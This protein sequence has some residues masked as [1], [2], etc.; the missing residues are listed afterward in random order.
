MADTQVALASRIQKWDSD[1][2]PEYVRESGFMPYMGKASGKGSNPGAII[3]T[4][5]DLQAS[6]KV[7]NMP[8]IGRTRGPGVRGNKRLTGAEVALDNY[9]CPITVKTIRQAHRVSEQEEHW[10]E[11]D[12]RDAMKTG[13]RNWSAEYLRDDFIMAFADVWGKSWAGGQD[14]ALEDDEATIYTPT[15]FMAALNADQTNMDAW[16]SANRDRVLYGPDL[17]HME[18]DYDHSDSVV[19]LTASTDKASA[20]VLRLA[21]GRAKTAGSE[22]GWFHIKPTRAEMSEG[23]EYFVWFVGSADFNNLKLDTEIAQANRDAR[24]RGVDNHPIF[25]DG[26]LIFDGVIIREIP[27]IPNFGNVGA[28]SAPVTMSFFCGAQAVGLAWAKRPSSRVSTDTDYGHFTGLAI[29]EMRAA[30][31][32]IFNTRQTGVVTVFCTAA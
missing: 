25:Q 6:G 3:L 5:T 31:K 14:A 24:A 10:T 2:Q 11:M 16:L 13:L 8:F 7:I 21:K 1:Y 12:L 4:K 30:K 29:S 32:L 18:A 28:T 26:D 22:E 17:A 27:E 19:K 15:T 23:R 20:T 9:N